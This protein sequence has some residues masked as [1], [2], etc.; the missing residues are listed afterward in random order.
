M[1]KA[2]PQL[3]GGGA[4][5]AS[6]AE[7]SRPDVKS[8]IKDFALESGFDLVQVTSAREFTEDRA[9]TLERLQAGLMDG[10]PWFTESRVL[11]RD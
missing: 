3:N 10:L 6:A 5:P 1:G 7:S 2:T 4:G 9:V 8:A 11:Q